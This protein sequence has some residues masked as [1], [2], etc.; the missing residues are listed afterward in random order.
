MKNY[1]YIN[2]KTLQIETTIN[3]S[4][5]DK[6]QTQLKFQSDFLSIFFL[7]LTFLF[8]SYYTNFY[9][10]KNLF[11]NIYIFYIIKFKD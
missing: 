10:F 8:N 9:K 5:I 6:F 7:F 11:N 4:N 2:K 1:Y 3:D